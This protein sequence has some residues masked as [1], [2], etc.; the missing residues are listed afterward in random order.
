[1]RATLLLTPLLL[2]ASGPASVDVTVTGLRS[3]K[4]ALSVCVMT[5]KASFPACAKSGTKQRVAIT[6]TIVRVR[7]TGLATGRYAVTAFHDEDGDGKLKANFIGM[8]REGVGV[9]GKA[10]GIPSFDEAAISVAPGT[11]VTLAMR[12]L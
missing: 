4:G 9:S 11:A 10:G 1:M 8:P 3:T 6:G 2:A 5:D 12:Y 7:F